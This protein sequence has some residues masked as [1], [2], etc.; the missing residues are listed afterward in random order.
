MTQGS[1]VRQAAADVFRSV[2]E[3]AGGE[4]I[5]APFPEYA[6]HPFEFFEEKLG[7]RYLTNEQIEIVL[8]V[9]EERETNVAGS[10]SFGKTFVAALLLLWWVYCVGGRVITTAPRDSQVALIWE[11]V[12]SIWARNAWRLGGQCLDRSLKLGG[13]KRAYG[14]VASRTAKEGF[15]GRHDP[16]LMAIVDEASGMGETEE[17]GIVA[18]LTDYRNRLLR[19]GNPLAGG[20]VFHKACQRSHIKIPIWTHPNVSWA[21]GPDKKLLPEVAAKITEGDCGKVIRREDWPEEFQRLGG[22]IPGGPSVESIEERRAEKGRGPGSGWWLSRH[23]AEFPEEHKQALV[24]RAWFDAARARYDENPVFWKERAMGSQCVFGVD[25]GDGG[26]PHAIAKRRGKVVQQVDLIPTEKGELNLVWIKDELRQRIRST[27]GS[28]A[29][30][31][32]IGIGSGPG[33]ELVNEGFDVWD[34]KVGETS[35]DPDMYANTKAERFW[36]LRLDFEAGDIAMA[37]L[38]QEIEDLLRDELAAIRYDYA[39]KGQI[40]IEP[41]EKT[42]ARL[43][44]ESYNLADALMLTQ[45]VPLP[46]DEEGY[47]DEEIYEGGFIA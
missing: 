23:D 47:F 5:R 25:V 36:L 13:R 29:N 44:G 4:T 2:V 34:V 45:D 26:D 41:K 27:L 14:Y 19:T 40:R 24:H 21:Y 20:T 33:Q 6:D 1:A 28:K 46:E 31:D 10:I 18:N 22:R 17:D 8:H 30:Y 12:Q 16:F 38:G 7:V 3:G 39:P 9:M 43:G 11:E 42:K 37:P 35:S 15:G 32:A